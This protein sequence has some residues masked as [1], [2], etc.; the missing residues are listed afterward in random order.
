MKALL[1]GSDGH[2]WESDI[3]DPIPS[4]QFWFI[5]RLFKLSSVVMA[6]FGQVALYFEVPA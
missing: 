1:R 6:P 2:W 3:G 4:P 5:G